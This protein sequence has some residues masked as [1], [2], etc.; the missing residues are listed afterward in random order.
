MKHR[1]IYSNYRKAFLAGVTAHRI[2]KGGAQ[3]LTEG[4]PVRQLMEMSIVAQDLCDP[5]PTPYRVLRKK[6][7]C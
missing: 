1:R 2:R 5:R 7:L 4:M 3:M 6:G